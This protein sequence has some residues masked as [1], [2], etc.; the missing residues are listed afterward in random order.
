MDCYPFAPTIVRSYK[1]SMFLGYLF[2]FAQV[3][4]NVTVRLKIK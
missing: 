2:S 4:F 1:A 3:S